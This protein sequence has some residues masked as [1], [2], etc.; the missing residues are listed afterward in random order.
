MKERSL[1]GKPVVLA[2]STQRRLAMYA[3]AA[4][5]A[6]VTMMALEMPAEAKIIYTPTH[7]TLVP[8]KA[9]PIDLNKDGI[10]DFFLDQY[11]N[12][13]SDVGMRL[14]ACQ[15][16][17][18]ISGNVF[19]YYHRTGAN[20]IRVT[21]SNKWAKCNRFGAIIKAG[22]RF[23]KQIYGEGVPLGRGGSTSFSGPWMDGGKGVKNRY[24]GLKFKINE[25]FHYGWARITVKIAGPRHVTV[26]LTG[27]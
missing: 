11:Y 2:E 24:L 10:A 27:Y 20:A 1:P 18:S 4:S 17:Y 15:Y 8:G 13:T 21:E 16:V 12:H 25:R 5:A 19:C 22:D 3:L 14:S 6:G 7:V 9:T 23:D 26:V